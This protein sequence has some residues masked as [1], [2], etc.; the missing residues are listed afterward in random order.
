MTDE[1]Y[2]FWDNDTFMKQIGVVHCPGFRRPNVV[3][4]ARDAAAAAGHREGTMTQAR[5]IRKV[6]KTRR[7]FRARLRSRALMRRIHG[8]T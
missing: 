7:G 5:H 1:E 3:A 2:L 8:S 4:S 6:I